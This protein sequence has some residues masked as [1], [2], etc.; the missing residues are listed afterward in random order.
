MY[1]VVIKWRGY[2]L[3]NFESWTSLPNE[4]ADCNPLNDGV[5][6]SNVSALLCGEYNIGDELG[7]SNFA[8]ALS[9]ISSSGVTCS[10]IFNVAPGVYDESVDL[11]LLDL[12]PSISILFRSQSG[13]ASNTELFYSGP[14]DFTLRLSS[15]Q[16]IS[17]EN[18]SITRS[19]GLRNVEIVES[20][21]VSFSN[22]IIRN[23]S[24]LGSNSNVYGLEISSSSNISFTDCGVEAQ[25]TNNWSNSDA[26]GIVLN[27]ST[28]IDFSQCS[29][30]TYAAYG[31]TYTMRVDS[32]SDVELV[33][34][35]FYDAANT[36]NGYGGRRTMLAMN[37]VDS[38]LVQDNVFQFGNTL[39][40]N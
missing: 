6:L 39:P 24:N 18:I 33:E 2:A 23:T 32:S 19:N 37:T 8:D 20:V 40:I 31:S 34:N 21:Q 3:Y 9:A 4:F 12:D 28:S 10:L 1:L 16:N 26:H 17:F 15:N 13:D 25:N 30:S 27:T 14:I 5:L 36:N 29:I 22:C 38:A 7:F 11:G 35:S